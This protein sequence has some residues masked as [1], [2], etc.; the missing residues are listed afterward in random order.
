MRENDPELK[1]LRKEYIKENLNSNDPE[2]ILRC[3][4]YIL[5]TP[6]GENILKHAEK[7]MARIV[8]KEL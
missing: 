7:I 6:Q 2:K 1:K 4:R 5:R 3:V 8:K